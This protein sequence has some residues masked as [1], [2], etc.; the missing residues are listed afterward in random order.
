[1]SWT[2]EELDALVREAANDKKIAYKDAYWQEMEAMLGSTPVRK[3]LGWWWFSGVAFL[4]MIITA[5][6]VASNS[7]FETP[8]QSTILASI[9]EHSRTVKNDQII[10]RESINVIEAANESEISKVNS[11]NFE[12]SNLEKSVTYKNPNGT[13]TGSQDLNSSKKANKRSISNLDTNSEIFKASIIGNSAE[14]GFEKQPV[15]SE[16]LTDV[17]MTNVP[18]SKDAPAVT[19]SSL[20]LMNWNSTMESSFDRTQNNFPYLSRR[21]IGFYA[22]LSGGIGQSYLA[23]ERNNTMREF[24][25][26]GGVEFF[27]KKWSF[28]VGLGYRQ[29][30]VDNLTIQ[31]RK[32]YYTYGLLKINQSLNYDQLLFADLNLSANYRLGRSELGINTSPSYLLG[33]R[34][35]YSENREEIMGDKTVVSTMPSEKNQFVSSTNFKSFG[36]NL[37]LSYNYLLKRNTWIGL[38]VNTRIAGNLLNNSFSGTQRTVPIMVDFGIKKRF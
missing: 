38:N 23:S 32:Q 24:G 2:D 19:I 25:L 21:R 26:Q 11:E 10:E 3:T 1:M 34:L 9:N 31:N 16:D 35:N 22:S 13:N 20:Q 17:N 4:G 8:M 29:Q 27:T 36:V 5:A 33:A 15:V 28:G 7:T 14:E 6:F 37:G 18:E 30:F 12:Q